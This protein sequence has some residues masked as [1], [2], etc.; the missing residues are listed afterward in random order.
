MSPNLLINILHG[1]GVV[2]KKLE[3]SPKVS[4]LYNQWL[5]VKRA[6]VRYDIICDNKNKPATPDS[7][8]SQTHAVKNMSDDCVYIKSFV[9]MLV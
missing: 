8:S 1:G 2:S 7:L 9:C 3:I 5:C 4:P 6:N